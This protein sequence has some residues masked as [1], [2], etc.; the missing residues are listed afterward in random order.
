MGREGC[1]RSDGGVR[2]HLEQL[3]GSGPPSYH[4][5]QP[6]CNGLPLW[7]ETPIGRDWIR[8]DARIRESWRRVRLLHGGQAAMDEVD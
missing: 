2:T 6:R 5:P 8:E 1:G 3:G 4:G 7:W